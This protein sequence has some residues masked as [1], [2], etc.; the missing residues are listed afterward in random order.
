MN[1]HRVGVLFSFFLTPPLGSCADSPSTVHCLTV[2]PITYWISMMGELYLSQIYKEYREELGKFPF[3]EFL[4]YRNTT[5]I[6][7]RLGGEDG[8]MYL[9]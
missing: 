4:G 9:A 1:K 5:E 6:L 2:P 3:L 8:Q 7:A